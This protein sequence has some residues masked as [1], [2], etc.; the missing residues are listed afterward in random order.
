MERASKPLVSKRVNDLVRVRLDGGQRWDVCD[1]VR[2][3]ESNAE[4][5]WHVAEGGSPL[6]NSQIWRYMKKADERIERSFERSR[7]ILLKR[8]V[9]KLNHLYARATTS[10]EI[11]VAR[12]I[13][14]DLAEIRRLLPN[15]ADAL[16]RMVDDLT[17]RL[18]Q[19]EAKDGSSSNHPTAVP[20]HGNAG[21]GGDPADQAGAAYRS[22]GAAGD[23]TTGPA[24]G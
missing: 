3:Q 15:P 8:H 7:K 19:L 18:A 21:D 16:Q 6:S 1:Y 10:G 23:G 2:Q 4:S 22:Q 14:R 5:P 13:L 24:S 12:A 11:S 9:A 17:R 20:G